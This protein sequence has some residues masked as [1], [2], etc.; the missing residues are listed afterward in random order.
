MCLWA[1]AYVHL[2]MLHKW[3][4]TNSEF[5]KRRAPLASRRVHKCAWLMRGINKPGVPPYCH[6]SHSC[7]ITTKPTKIRVICT[8][9]DSRRAVYFWSPICFV[10]SDYVIIL[11]LSPFLT[12]VCV[13]M[14]LWQPGAFG[15]SVFCVVIATLCPCVHAFRF[16]L[17]AVRPGVSTTAA[18]LWAPL[19]QDKLR[20][21]RFS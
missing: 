20:L 17:P 10:H 2:R 1:C 5:S 4:N 13:K 14:A 6:A 19:P 15:L 16:L 3:H 8:F 11:S 21:G 7:T 12:L 9:L 18:G